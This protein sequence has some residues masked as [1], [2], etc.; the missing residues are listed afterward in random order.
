VTKPLPASWLPSVV[1][2]R[3]HVSVISDRR[4][5]LSVS[6]TSERNPAVPVADFVGVD[7]TELDFARVTR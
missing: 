2:P 5:S 6:K 1:V 3:R 7:L 4:V